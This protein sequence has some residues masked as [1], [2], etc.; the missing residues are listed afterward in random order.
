MADQ[1]ANRSCRPA[2]FLLDRFCLLLNRSWP[3][4]VMS[5]FSRTAGTPSRISFTRAVAHSGPSRVAMF[6]A[7]MCFRPVDLPDS[8]RSAS[9]D[10]C[11]LYTLCAVCAGL[12]PSAESGQTV[13]QRRGVDDLQIHVSSSSRS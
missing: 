8:D 5:T 2:C 1:H 11:G 12:D 10:A 7:S 3:C 13:S 6:L 9:C 4:S